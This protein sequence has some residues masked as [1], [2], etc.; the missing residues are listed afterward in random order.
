MEEPI[1]ETF[2]V[3]LT[4]DHPPHRVMERHRVAALVGDPRTHSRTAA[5]ASA[6][7]VRLAR[8]MTGGLRPD[9]SWRLIDLAADG[10]WERRPSAEAASSLS[11]AQIVVIASPVVNASFSELLKI[12]LDGL[13]ERALEGVVAVPVMIGRTGRHTLAAD[14]H[15]RPVLIELGA[16]CPTHSLFALESRLTN[17]GAVCGAW[18]ARAR[19]ALAHLSATG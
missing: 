18:F 6:V 10:G 17:P 8:E 14:L 15:L 12:F 1:T 2:P 5:L 19:P 13:P 7:A 16:S 9:A 3:D 4:L 11:S